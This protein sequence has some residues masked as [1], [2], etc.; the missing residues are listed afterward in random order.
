MLITQQFM[1]HHRIN[2]T[3]QLMNEVIEAAGKLGHHIPES[4]AEKNIENTK[5][6]GAYRPS[7]LI[8]YLEYRE[9]EVEETAEGSEALTA[10][11]E[12]LLALLDGRVSLSLDTGRLRISPSDGE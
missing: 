8:D 11:G 6:M 4:F 12:E 5:S 1:N 7:S 10:I 2:L 3:R 9:V